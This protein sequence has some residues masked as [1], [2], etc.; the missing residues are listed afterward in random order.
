MD[1]SLSFTSIA[2]LFVAMIVGAAMPTVSSLAVLART[3]ASGFTHG[4]LTALGI[5]AGDITFI[6]IA[7]YGLSFLAD[8]LG[9][10]FVIVKY[11]GGAYLIW[12]GATL[13]MSKA[14]SAEIEGVT[15]SSLLA[16]FL[17]G[18]FITL[19]D[20]KAIIFYLGFLPAFIDM[21]TISII[22]TGI[23]LIVATVAVGTP[24][25]AYAI[26]ADRARLFS[27]NARAKK[28][29]NVVAGSIMI[30]VGVFLIIQA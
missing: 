11:L 26:M 7:I 23:I 10:L 24:K 5:V 25:L 14:D 21:V 30:A 17:T 8:M 13:W 2:A 6:L 29:I 15:E 3:A 4:V 19:V 27:K 1:I 22:D 9:D 12:L 28:V 18:L 20:L 16:S